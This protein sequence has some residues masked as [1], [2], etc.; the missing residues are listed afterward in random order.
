MLQWVL[1]SQPLPK[2]SYLER[3]LTE[4]V[5]FKVSLKGYNNG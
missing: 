4:I 3:I 1:Q 2:K 5:I